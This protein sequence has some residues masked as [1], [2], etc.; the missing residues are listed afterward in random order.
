MTLR[1]ARTLA[2]ALGVTIDALYDAMAM[3]IPENGPTVRQAGTS[4]P[5]RRA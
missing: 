4:D 5:A 1:T 2:R 3:R